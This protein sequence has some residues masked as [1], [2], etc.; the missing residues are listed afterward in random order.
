MHRS[1]S[2][3][4][5]EDLYGFTPH[6]SCDPH[7]AGTLLPTEDARCR[8]LASLAGLRHSGTLPT[9]NLSPTITVSSRHG[10]AAHPR[11]GARTVDNIDMHTTARAT[12]L[13]LDRVTASTGPTERCSTTS[14]QLA[15]PLITDA[16]PFPLRTHFAPPPTGSLGCVAFRNGVRTLTAGLAFTS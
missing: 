3:R 10:L 11:R 4:C 14:E 16:W 1:R 9:E 8:S 13:P 15:S 6:C 12:R 7:S 2:P 5:R